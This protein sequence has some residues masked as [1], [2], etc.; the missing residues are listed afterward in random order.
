MSKTLVVMGKRLDTTSVLGI[1]MV[2]NKRFHTYSVKGVGLRV[3][4]G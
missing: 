1:W 2:K 3:K 4:G